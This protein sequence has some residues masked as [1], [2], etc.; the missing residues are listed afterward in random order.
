MADPAFISAASLRAYLELNT[1]SSSSKYDDGTLGSNIRAASAFLQ[2]R[3]GRQFADQTATKLF[4][5]QGR[6][7]ITIPGL[8]AATTVTQQSTTLTAD[9]TYWLLPDSQ[10][11]GVYTGIAFRGFGGRGSALGYLSNP[12]WFDRNLDTQWGRYGGYYSLPNDLSIAGTWGH[13]DANLPEPLLHA[14][15]VLA[16]WYTLRPDSILANV[17]VSPEGTVRDYSNLPPEVLAF[18][19]DWTLGTDMA[20][21][22]G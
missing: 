1:V 6:T 19:N 20:V 17:S 16:G 9:S 13:T 21:W 12:E 15:K 4:T 11:T 14:T 5:T 8:R 7:A 22:V 3:T 18:L 10:N 2:R